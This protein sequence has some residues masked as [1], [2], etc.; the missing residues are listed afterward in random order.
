MSRVRTEGF[1]SNRNAGPFVADE[2]NADAI[3][4]LMGKKMGRLGDRFAK[5]AEH[6]LNARARKGRSPQP[7]YILSPVGITDHPQKF[8]WS[9][10]PP[11]RGVYRVWGKGK[12][13][14][15]T[16]IF[17]HSYG[18]S[19][20]LGYLRRNRSR[21]FP[22]GDENG[23]HP[24]RWYAGIRQ[25]CALNTDPTKKRK[26]GASIHFCIS[27]RG[28][29][30]VSVDVNDM[31]WHGGGKRGVDTPMTS[32]GNN[33]YTVG[34][35]LEPALG[36]YK[37]SNGRLS[38]P[39]ILPYPDK[40]MLALAIVCKKLVTYRGNIPEVYLTKKNGSVRQQWEQYKAGYTTHSDVN[41]G[42]LDP[43]GQFDI[44]PGAIGTASPNPW[45]KGLKSGWDQLW[46]LM[47][48]MRFAL[49]TDIFVKDVAKGD[50]ANMA[51]LSVAMM[52]T[53][54][55]GQRAMVQ[56][57]RDRLLALKRAS[58][59]QAQERR[60][61]YKQATSHATTMTDVI[62]KGTANVTKQVQRFSV[63]GVVGIGGPV[64]TFDFET[65]TWK[66]GGA[67]TGKAT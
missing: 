22:P 27:R 56:Q 19:W 16:C 36:R 35:E 9:W 12:I 33:Y 53:T 59:M 50:F 46:G 26:G 44:L 62:A 40:Q 30:V 13:R 51:D 23:F 28:D 39:L 64:Q 15:W 43:R 17:L 4:S 14:P 37:Y 20:D 2:L 42:K 63:A 3:A 29:V 49:A 47:R 8:G 65:G 58:S 11:T 41:S 25:L 55:A 1:T 38:R 5:N 10:I 48:P 24:S 21:R 66:V 7:E 52:K 34:F 54:N 57:H 67:D 60:Y 31:A 45:M 61:V 32:K 6:Y 18:Y